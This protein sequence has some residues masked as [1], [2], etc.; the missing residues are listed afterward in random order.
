[1][2]LW[3]GCMIL[4]GIADFVFICKATGR[5]NLGK[6]DINKHS[7]DTKW[8][9]LASRRI[10]LLNCTSTMCFCPPRSCILT[11]LR[12]GLCCVGLVM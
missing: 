10:N 1:M 8:T 12:T 11:V 2:V 4:V 9:A 5:Q 7:L 6:T 3:V